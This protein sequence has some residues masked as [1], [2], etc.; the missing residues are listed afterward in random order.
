MRLY[1]HEFPSSEGLCYVTHNQIREIKFKHY[2]VTS[3]KYYTIFIRFK[4]CD[5]KVHVI[6]IELFKVYTVVNFDELE[7]FKSQ[8]IQLFSLFNKY[9]EYYWLP[10][11]QL[12]KS[13]TTQFFNQLVEL[14]EG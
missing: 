10:K 6:N 12:P 3:N 13:L 7:L 9:N 11:A 14:Y 2:V 8:C 1:L 5:V 4:W